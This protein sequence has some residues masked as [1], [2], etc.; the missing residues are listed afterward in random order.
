MQ[1]ASAIRRSSRRVYPVTGIM[2]YRHVRQVRYKI[3]IILPG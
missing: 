1:L 3:P 2:C